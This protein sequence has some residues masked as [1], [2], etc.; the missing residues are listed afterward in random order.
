MDRLLSGPI[1]LLA[2]CQMFLARALRPGQAKG[3]YPA[4]R[5]VLFLVLLGVVLLLNPIVVDFNSAATA[6]ESPMCF[7]AAV[8]YLYAAWRVP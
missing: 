2:V 8:L 4:V 5:T 3:L 7:A 1:L 6:L